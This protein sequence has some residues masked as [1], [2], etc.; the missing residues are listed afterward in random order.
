MERYHATHNIAEIE[1]SIEIL[2]QGRFPRYVG[3]FLADGL[4]RMSEY[5]MGKGL[6]TCEPEEMERLKRLTGQK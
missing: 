5:F 1:R 3:R 6:L 2:L 4:Y